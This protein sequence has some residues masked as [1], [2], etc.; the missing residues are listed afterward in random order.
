MDLDRQIIEKKDF[1]IGRR[2]Y[3]PEAVDAHLE[4]VANE[5]DAL[6]R[7]AQHRTRPSGESLASVAASQVQAIVEAAETT[8]TD[9]RRQAEQ[10][11]RRV[12]QDAERAAE[13]TRDDAVQQAQ[14]HVE[15]VSKASALMLQRVDAMENEVNA[16]VESL[17]TGTN[18]LTA[19]LALLEGNMGE[20]YE[21]SG[22]KSTDA[23]LTSAPAAVPAFG[24]EQPAEDALREEEIGEA[25]SYEPSYEDAAVPDVVEEV[26]I[27]ETDVDEPESSEMAIE[28]VQAVE[29]GI[30]E[31]DTSQLEAEPFVEPP[32]P[33]PEP[34]PE[35]EAAAPVEEA[36]AAE[37]SAGAASADL[38]GARLIA[39]NM[40]LNGQPREEADRYLADNFDIPDRKALLDE[41]YAAVEG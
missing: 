22:H 36:A 38:D 2:G 7:A 6:R 4:Q 15:A 40:A 39:L 29:F 19:D 25:V 17:R 8:A 41:V 10:D 37:D 13:H 12:N 24:E 32:P 11:A 34:E 9:I 27:A 21:A 26:V 28:E 30:A 1:P 33:E 18:R 3:D 14:A 35:P 16:L 31:I 5:V 20:L 23:A